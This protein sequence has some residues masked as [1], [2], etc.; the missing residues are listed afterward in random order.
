MCVVLDSGMY[1][2]ARAVGPVLALPDWHDF[3]NGVNEP[4]AGF[5]GGLTVR[6]AHSDGDAGLA[7]LQAPQPVHD[8]AGR[9]RP[10]SAG[11]AGELVQL[12]LGHF[13]IAFVVER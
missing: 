10:A 8:E 1:P 3:F 5:E 12:L 4:L 11:L 6:G 7:E 13:G 2:L 9:Q